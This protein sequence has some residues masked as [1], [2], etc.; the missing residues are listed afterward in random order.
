MEF[1]FRR[2]MGPREI[3]GSNFSRIDSPMGRVPQKMET[4]NL[5]EI[6]VESV[7]SLK[8]PLRSEA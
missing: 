7:P 4:I 1:V 6:R 3:S 2:R 8:A 5:Q